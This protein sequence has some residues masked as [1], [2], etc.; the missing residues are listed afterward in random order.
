MNQSISL[1]AGIEDQKVSVLQRLLVQAEEIETGCSFKRFNQIKFRESIA[2]NPA[3]SGLLMF[4][5]YIIKY[6]GCSL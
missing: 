5:K 4:E 1:A 6:Q 2:L 3:I